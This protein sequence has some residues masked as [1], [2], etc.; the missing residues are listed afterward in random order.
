MFSHAMFVDV[1]QKKF[2]S[3]AVEKYEIGI[4]CLADKERE[5]RRHKNKK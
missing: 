3:N 1:L 2:G 5:W 4:I